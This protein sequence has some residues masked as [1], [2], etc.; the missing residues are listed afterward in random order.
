MKNLNQLFEEILVEQS[1]S[2]Y[3]EYFNRKKGSFSIDT[4]YS[5]LA[6]ELEGTLMR[7]LQKTKIKSAEELEKLAS[8]AL[9]IMKDR[10]STSIQ[11]YFFDE[12]D[13]S[14]SL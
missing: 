2:T 11:D 10:L 1:L 5:N 8:K 13:G 14:P 6:Y 3:E 9:E 4:I 12:P 7:Y